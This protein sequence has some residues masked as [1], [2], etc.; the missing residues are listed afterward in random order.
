MRHRLVL[1]AAAM[2]PADEHL[3]DAALAR[4]FQT[5]ATVRRRL[6]RHSRQ[7]FGQLRERHPRAIGS[8]DAI[9]NC[10]STWLRPADLLL[11]V[12]AVRALLLDPRE[13]RRVVLLK[14]LAAVAHRAERHALFQFVAL[15]AHEPECQPAVIV[16]WRLR[17]A[18]TADAER[19]FLARLAAS[20]DVP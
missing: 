14:F 11:L 4:H 18:R 10:S 6:I 3:L 20:R 15:G 19:A 13:L 1:H 17:D 8:G 2:H 5:A 12:P 16:I 7:E 9:Q